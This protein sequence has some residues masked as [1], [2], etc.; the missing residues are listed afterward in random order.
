M[1][2]SGGGY[3]SRDTKPLLRQ[4]QNSQEK[5]Q[6]AEYDA[7]T[8]NLLATYL[9]DFNDRD[10][11]AVAERLR[12]IREALEDEI[13][14][15]VDMVFGGSVSKRTYVEGLSDIDA[16]V[17]LNDSDLA[18]ATPE[19]LCASRTRRYNYSPPFERV[20][21]SIFQIRPDPIGR[22]FGRSSSLVR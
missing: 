15:T 13:E 12:A 8:N 6:S 21:L 11:E 17:L 9:S 10:T 1:G 2:G 3:F 4:L 16:L 20:I 19:L 5:S 18:T 7:A 22:R 14:G